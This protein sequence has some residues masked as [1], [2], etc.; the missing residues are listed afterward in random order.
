MSLNVFCLRYLVFGC[1]WSAIASHLPRRTDNEIKN[2]WNTH[3]K[4]RLLQMGIDPVTHKSTMEPEQQL[5]SCSI[6]PGLRSVVS[7]NLTH[8]SQWDSFRAEA[9]VRLSRQ[10]S[11]TSADLQ[12][13]TS[14]QSPP[15]PSSHLAGAKT[16]N[17]SGSASSTFMSS[18][19]AQVAETLRPSFGVVDLDKTTPS[20]PVNLQT[21]LQDWES[22]LQGPGHLKGAPQFGFSTHGSPIDVPDNLRSATPSPQYDNPDPMF[23][24]SAQITERLLVA[25]RCSSDFFPPPRICE[26]SMMFPMDSD[27]QS[28]S[29]AGSTFSFAGNVCAGDSTETQFSPTSTLHT[30]NS[31]HE[32]SYTSSPN[33]WVSNGTTSISMFPLIEGPGP[34]SFWTRQQVAMAMADAG[35]ISFNGGCAAAVPMVNSVMG[36]P[37]IIPIP[38]FD[39]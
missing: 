20:N 26:N 21:F 38:Q 39:F 6:I 18:W 25:S 36:M 37:N 13:T 4:K 9:E 5:D 15:P 32:S 34:N 31:D 12:Q 1:R 24:T 7:S 10:S 17:Q 11:L 2:Y 27:S 29:A 23:P 22:L 30:N 14:S 33:S 28:L 3:L 19:R 35:L 16:P 8:M